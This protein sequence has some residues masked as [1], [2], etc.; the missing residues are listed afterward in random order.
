MTA[1]ASDWHGQ[2]LL[3]YSFEELLKICPFSP[4][5]A[6]PFPLSAS[7]VEW[8]AAVLPSNYPDGKEVAL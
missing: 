2:E 3:H 5:V 1:P 8:D 6:A 7:H 4:Q